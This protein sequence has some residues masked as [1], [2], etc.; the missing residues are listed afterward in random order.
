V[1]VDEAG[2]QDHT[3]RV[4]DLGIVHLKARGY[5]RDAVCLHQQVATG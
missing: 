4:D 5:G 3:G 2:A 1:G